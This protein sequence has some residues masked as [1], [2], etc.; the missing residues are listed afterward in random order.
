MVSHAS[1]N[2]KQFKDSK[3]NKSKFDSKS[4]TDKT[5]HNNAPDPGGTTGDDWGEVPISSGLAFLIIGSSIYLFKR[6]KDD[7]ETC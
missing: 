5:Q 6:I 4:F 2:D 1:D 3:V 7:E